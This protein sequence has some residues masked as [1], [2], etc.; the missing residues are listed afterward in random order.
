MDAEQFRFLMH[1]ADNVQPEIMESWR[2]K[3][4]SWGRVMHI[5][6]NVSI[7]YEDMKLGGEYKSWNLI[8]IC[9]SL[10]LLDNKY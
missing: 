5:G 4:E 8:L 3:L 7:N 1:S 9:S 6:F 2:W 10:V